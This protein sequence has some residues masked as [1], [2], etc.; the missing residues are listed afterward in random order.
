MDVLAI[1]HETRQRNPSYIGPKWADFLLLFITLPSIALGK[2]IV[3]ELFS[4]FYMR[5]LPQKHQG[6]VREQKIRKACENIFKAGYFTAI[7]IFGYFAVIKQLPFE[8]PVFGNGSWHN[9]FINFPYTVF[10][11]ATTYY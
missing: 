6:K 5:S 10:L 3:Y 11:P 1:V 8:S 4:G 9:Y 2:Y 7:S